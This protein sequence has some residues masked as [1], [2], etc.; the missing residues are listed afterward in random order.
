MNRKTGFLA[1]CLFSTSVA[2][3]YCPP[4]MTP[5]FLTQMSTGFAQLKA[6]FTTGLNTL[7]TSVSSALQLERS[8]ILGAIGVQTQQEAVNASNIAHADME[9]ART[10][11][12]AI[13]A[14]KQ[15][16]RIKD[17]ALNYGAAGQGYN[18][19]L[20]LNERRTIT[21][22]QEKDKEIRADMVFQN[23]TAGTGKFANPIKAQ[24][25]A[26]K[27]HHDYFCTSEQ[28]AAGLCLS[29][30]EM[31]GANLQ[32]STLFEYSS[33]TDKYAMAKSSFI[34]NMV[35]LPDAPLSE[36]AAKTPRGQEYLRQKF[37]K[38]AVISPALNSLMAIQSEFTAT[39]NGTESGQPVK[40]LRQQYREQVDRYLG[41][42]EEYK[43][44]NRSLVGQ[45]ER[46]VLVE[47]LKEG[48]LE[49]AIMGNKH[50]QNERIESMLASLVSQENKKVNS[51]TNKNLA[52]SA[53]A[54][55]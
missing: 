47:I 2:A 14:M 51:L 41:H 55:K 23:V 53:T 37:E 18:P 39:P 13:G 16:D 33:S 29:V 27:L 43:N 30:G 40:P 26:L 35:G 38:D 15:S 7:D 8:M 20:V 28:A 6:T 34:N 1:L 54:P 24:D 10:T 4:Y 45:T 9:I 5:T 42:G 25:E 3:Y 22:T 17:T 21:E 52:G 11:A 50:A 49:L 36:T 44:W 46:G 12:S 32:A 19:C 48:A 31:Q